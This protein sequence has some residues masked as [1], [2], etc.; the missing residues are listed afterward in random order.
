MDWN[1]ALVSFGSALGG[2]LIGAYA[3]YLLSRK[4][5][6]KRSRIE[7]TLRLMEQYNSPDFL[8]MR[9]DADRILRAYFE[10]HPP[11][12]WNE[13]YHNLKESYTPVSAVEHF[14][15][16]VLFF[17]EIR[18]I[19]DDMARKFWSHHYNHWYSKYFGSLSDA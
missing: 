7:R 15:Q 14:F 5:D 1:N 8:K 12:S 6:I 18:E 10:T 4:Q 2:A 11:C 3:S 17:H 13:L 16:Q 19:E 9:G